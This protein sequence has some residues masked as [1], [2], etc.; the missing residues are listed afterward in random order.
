MS[1]NELPSLVERLETLQG[2]H[3][4]TATFAARLQALERATESARATLSSNEAAVSELEASVA[5][6]LEIMSKNVELLDAK[7]AK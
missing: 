5:A 3:T 1:A 2:L 6:N 4:Q 7:F